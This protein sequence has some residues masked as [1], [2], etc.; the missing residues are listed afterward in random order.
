MVCQVSTYEGLCPGAIHYYGTLKASDRSYKYQIK[1]V[2]VVRNL[3]ASEADK[4]N[5]SQRDD[6]PKYK[7]GETSN[8]F[9]SE[10]SLLKEAIRQW[11]RHF[12]KARLLLRGS[13]AT[14]GPQVVLDCKDAKLRER[15]KALYKQAE[16]ID[17]YE[18]DFER[19]DEI[20]KRWDKA[21]A[22]A[23]KGGRK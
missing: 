22:E 19:M 13:F 9:N 17:F 1:S 23:D 18:N 6:A 7:K 16:Q 2:E 21:L 5:L 20:A 10:E 8:K 3:S 15:L 4:L 11:K 14:C 12:P